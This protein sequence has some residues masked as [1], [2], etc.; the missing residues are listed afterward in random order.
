MSQGARFLQSVLL[1]KTQEERANSVSIH[2]ERGKETK[3]AWSWSGLTGKRQLAR[4][5]FACFS[6]TLTVQF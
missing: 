6:F 5:A 2:L 1:A 3:R 4:G